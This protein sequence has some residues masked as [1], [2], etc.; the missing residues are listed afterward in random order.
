M[1]IDHADE[2][3]KRGPSSAVKARAQINFPTIL[4]NPTGLRQHRV[5]ML[6]RTLLRFHVIHLPVVW[7]GPGW[8][9]LKRPSTLFSRDDARANTW[10]A[11]R[12]FGRS[13]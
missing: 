9:S 8:I 4:H 3:G 6:A 11:L 12:A 7:Y 13:A 10:Y 5:D 2:R 1:K